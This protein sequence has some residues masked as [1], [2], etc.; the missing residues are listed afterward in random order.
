M[1]DEILT[2]EATPTRLKDY[3][4]M[5]NNTQIPFPTSVEDSREVKENVKQIVLGNLTL[6]DVNSNIRQ[7]CA[8]KLKQIYL[9]G[10]F[11]NNYNY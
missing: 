3:P 4:Y 10:K 9:Q 11:N 2:E 7:Q 8:V 6:D 1:A 5:I